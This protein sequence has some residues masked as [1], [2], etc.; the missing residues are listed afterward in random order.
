MTKL[1]LKVLLI[2][3]STSAC[4]GLGDNV[5]RT[6]DRTSLLGFG[7]ATVEKEKIDNY[8]KSINTLRGFYR[9]IQVPDEQGFLHKVGSRKSQ[10]GSEKGIELKHLPAIREGIFAYVDSQC[11]AYIDAIFWANRSRGAAT[12][13]NG[14]IAGATGAIAGASGVAG[15]TLAIIAAAFGLGNNLFDSYYDT[16]L[17]SLEPSGIQRLVSL[18]RLRYR[19]G[20][21]T[22]SP[23]KSEGHLLTQ[24]QDYIRLC[25]PAYIEFL[26][27]S[28]IQDANVVNASQSE[29]PSLLLLNN[30]VLQPDGT[31]I[32]PDD[33]VY[34]PF[35]DP[36]L[37]EDSP[38]KLLDNGKIEING[39]EVN[40]NGP[41]KNSAEPEPMPDVLGQTEGTAAPATSNATSRTTSTVSDAVPTTTSQPEASVS[42]TNP[43]DADQK[44]KGTPVLKTNR[45]INTTPF[46]DIR[47][48]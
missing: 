20:I 4:S 10:D 31:I 27:N 30:F 13:A 28:S 3:A 12:S 34:P 36:P 29:A 48:K 5:Q 41:W 16:F 25:T 8:S 9:T 23:L 44:R 6:I 15:S 45:R 19:E 24:V 33:Q 32:G 21:E 40:L 18:S 7:G 46:I 14:A 39:D 47:N 2:A 43:T 11:D 17:Y 1:Y 35:G 38:F 37:P 26:V 42:E 22:N